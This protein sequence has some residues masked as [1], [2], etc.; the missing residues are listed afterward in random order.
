MEQY[1]KTFQ[2]AFGLYCRNK[3]RNDIIKCREN[4]RKPSKIRQIITDMKDLE[5]ESR[6]MAALKEISIGG[7]SRTFS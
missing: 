5:I 6:A 3:L 7:K 1:L 2:F 4:I